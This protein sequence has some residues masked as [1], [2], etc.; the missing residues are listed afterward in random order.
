MNISLNRQVFDKDKFTKT[1][2]TEFTQ[3]VEQ[4]NPT[5]FDINLATIEDFFTLYNNFFFQIPKNGESNSHEFL[6]KESSQYIDFQSNNEE[7]NALLDE[8]AQLRQENLELRQQNI[9]ITTQLASSQNN[10]TNTGV[11]PTNIRAI[12][13]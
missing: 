3:L 11:S 4:P 8:I 2:N 7:I 9:D 12:A 5:F 13:R 1:V 6:V 10:I